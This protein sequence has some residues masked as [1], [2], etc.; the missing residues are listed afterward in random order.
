MFDKSTRIIID[1]CVVST[2]AS[3]NGFCIMHIRELKKSEKNL[4]LNSLPRI[5]TGSRNSDLS[6]LS[7]MLSS[8]S[9]LTYDQLIANLI[10]C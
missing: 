2:T 10:D 5:S 6:L 1:E 9:S 7:R 8:P 3:R 4:D